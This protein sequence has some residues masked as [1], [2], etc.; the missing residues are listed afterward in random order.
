MIPAL[1]LLR[2]SFQT[3]QA[4]QCPKW[5]KFYNFTVFFKNI[6]TAQSIK[7][8]QC[9]VDQHIFLPCWM[10]LCIFMLLDCCICHITT[11]YDRMTTVIRIFTIGYENNDSA[12]WVAWAPVSCYLSIDRRFG[13]T[14][15]YGMGLLITVWAATPPSPCLL[16]GGAGDALKGVLWWKML[17]LVLISIRH[18]IKVNEQSRRF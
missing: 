8:I 3:R 1:P 16:A 4:N 5:R 18:I 11:S 14:I 10:Y 12:S 6:L 2:R 15:R 9:Q 13:V 17:Y 7:H